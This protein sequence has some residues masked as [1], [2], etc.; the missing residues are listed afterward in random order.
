MPFANCSS[1]SKKS[2]K[3]FGTFGPSCAA[4]APIGA[5]GAKSAGYLWTSAIAAIL[6]GPWQTRQASAVLTAVLRTA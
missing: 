1:R 3:I 4:G 5:A 2:P 6:P